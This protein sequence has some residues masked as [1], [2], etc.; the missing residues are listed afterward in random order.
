MCTTH[1]TT[2][3][4][5]PQPPP[6]LFAAAR[7]LCA[8]G[9][10]LPGGA[11]LAVFCCCASLTHLLSALTHVWPD[12]HALEKLDHLGIV[13]LIVGTPLTQLMVRVDCCWAGI[14]GFESAPKQ[15]KPACWQP[16][17]AGARPG[18]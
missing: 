6:H 5:K 2:W 1:G 11:A 12:D 4:R 18:R 8:R 17:H 10:V 7:R 13:A 9:G 16:T 3:R 14:V 15:S